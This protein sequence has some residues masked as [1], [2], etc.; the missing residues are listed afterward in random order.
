MQ[1]HLAQLVICLIADM[2][3]TADPGVLSL[4]T[5]QPHIIVEISQELISTA[6]ILLYLIKNGCCQLQ[7]KVCAQRIG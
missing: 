1:G 7:A 2:Y 6:V 3:P 5:A 4:I